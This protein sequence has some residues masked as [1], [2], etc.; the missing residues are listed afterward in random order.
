MSAAAQADPLASL[1]Q[2]LGQTEVEYLERARANPFLKWAGGKRTIVPEIV[3]HLPAQ[4]GTYY[5]P[6]LGGGAVFFSLDCR[7]TK[8]HLS[9]VNLELMLAYK[10][11]QKEPDKLI[12]ALKEHDA[13]HG[14]RH[15]KRV[16]DKQH[17]EQDPVLL[18]ARFIYLNR[19][20]YNGLYRVN[21]SGRFNV[22][23]GN[24]KKPLICD[25]DNL[26]A[27]SEVLQGV[28]LRG[29]PF[30][31]ID[32]QNGD[33][34]YCDPPYDG[35]FTD[36]TGAGFDDADQRELRDA[37][38]E[39]R[40]AGASVIV[41]NSDTPLIRSLYDGW[42]LHPIKAQRNINCKAGERGKETELLI[43]A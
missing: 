12:A 14:K 39:W 42:T 3:K 31:E 40:D 32:P 33:L 9:D 21:K 25:E 16:R 28:T 18:A 4:F 8:A 5:E 20:C 1:N 35:T 41:S 38:A 29:Q 23:M 10:M 37:C 17:D 27:V 7:I 26:K 24:Y 13:S 30:G 11:V 15:Y 2:V 19:T 36:Y 43:T 34:V 6:F 22:P